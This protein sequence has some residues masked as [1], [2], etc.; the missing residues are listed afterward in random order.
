MRRR[1]CSGGVRRASAAGW[2]AALC[3][4]ALALGARSVAAATASLSI[5][6]PPYGPAGAA[7]SVTY[8]VMLPGC[9]GLSASF[10]WDS[11]SG[12][13]V[14]R[15]VP[16]GPGPI[17]GECTATASITPP[18]SR[19][20]PGRHGVYASVSDRKL[21]GATLAATQYFVLPGVR[22]PA[23]TPV[24]TPT[25]G[26]APIA[27]APPA[28]TTQPTPAPTP[29]QTPYPTDTPLPTSTDT[30]SPLGGACGPSAAAG[31]ACPTPSPT[32][33][34]GIGPAG[35][36]SSNGGAGGKPFIIA[37]GVF[38]AILFGALTGLV[39]LS[40]RGRG[41]RPAPRPA[42]A[43]APAGALAV[44]SRRLPPAPAARFGGMP[45]VPATGPAVIPAAP[46][47]DPLP[48]PAPAAGPLFSFSTPSDPPA[49]PPEPP[50]TDMPPWPPSSPIPPWPRA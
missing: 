20:D 47:S 14:V 1:A 29:V 33:A 6:A 5:P 19:S 10:Y 43:P 13:P 21:A 4:V 34:A 17:S 46:V 25:A 16:L 8:G 28:H 42:P 15:D 44:R 9:D 37:A 48:P 12:T 3:A 11:P 23:P 31:A 26:V 24:P 50:S 41:S 39:L 36:T 38:I 30:G 2:A 49:D 35:P 45:G 22:T 18:P 27:V 40:G 7:F 32:P